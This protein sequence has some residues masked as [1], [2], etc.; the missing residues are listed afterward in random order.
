M[1]HLIERLLKIRV[2]SIHL[3]TLIKN[4]L[5]YDIIINL[6][7]SNVL[8]QNHVEKDLY[9]YKINK[10]FFFEIMAPKIVGKIDNLEIGL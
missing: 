5:N 3:R 8:V 4:L 7:E 9:Y 1:I 10:I 6:F 2:N